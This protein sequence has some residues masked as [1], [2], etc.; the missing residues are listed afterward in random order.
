MRTLRINVTSFDG[1]AI[2]LW[3]LSFLLRVQTIDLSWLLPNKIY[4]EGDKT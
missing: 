1:S 4:I 3:V 2:M